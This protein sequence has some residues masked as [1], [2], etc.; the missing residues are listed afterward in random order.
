MSKYDINILKNGILNADRVL[1]SQAI[2]LIESHKDEHRVLAIKLLNEILPHTGTAKRI[3]VSGSPGVGKSTFIQ[4]FA[5]SLSKEGNKVA[6]LAI[7]PT[8]VKSGGSILGDKTRMGKLTLDDNIYI[9]PTPSGKYLGGVAEKTREN[10]L[11]CEAYGFDYVLVETVGVGQSEI[12]V[13]NMVDCFLMLAQPGAGDELQGIKRGILEIVDLVVVNKADGDQLNS[14]RL[15]KV[16]LDNALHILR[17]AET[18]IPKTCLCSSIDRLGPLN[19]IELVHDYFS[20]YDFVEK[21]A[22]LKQKWLWE[23]LENRL[24]YKIFS[25]TQIKN[26]MLLFNSSESTSVP[27]FVENLVS[28]VCIK[29]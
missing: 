1:L 19:V 4:S 8:S 14:A 7:D 10:I 18:T 13:S 5:A 6:I 23:L 20:S 26:E 15:A 22:L 2:T 27:E 17:G 28:K 9:R 29:F 3:G 16:Q 21:R 24:R 11:L 12:S 25:D